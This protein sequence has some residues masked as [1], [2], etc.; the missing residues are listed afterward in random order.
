ML[1]REVKMKDSKSEL[2]I[3]ENNELKR[4]L[5]EMLEQVKVIV[6]KS[7]GKSD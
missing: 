6:N 4:E 1:Q 5:N 2:L 3:R 7:I